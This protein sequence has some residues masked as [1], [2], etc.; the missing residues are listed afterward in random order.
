MAVRRDRNGRWRYR[1]VV[2]L[3]SGARTR[4]SGTPALNT[5][6]D[7]ER[8][9]RDHIARVLDPPPAQKEVLTLERFIED[10]WWPVYPSAAGNRRTTVREKER[11]IRLYIKPQLGRVKL[12]QVR[13]EALDRF[14]AFLKQRKLSEKSRKNVGA[15]LR[16][17]LASAVEWDYLDAIP[18]FPKLRVPEADSD[19]F[20]KEES[21]LLIDKATD[22]EERALLMF[23]I[24]TGARQGEQ[25]GLSWGDIDWQNN[26]VVFRRAL[27]EGEVGPTKSGKVRKVPLTASF[28]AALKAIRHLRSERVFVQSDGKSFSS[29]Q[30]HDRLKR[31][32]R[33]AGLRRI[34][35]HDLRHSFGSQLAIAGVPLRQVQAWMGHS[36]IQ[37]TMRYA[38]L[39]PNGGAELIAA[40][41]APAQPPRGNDVAKPA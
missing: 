33:R 12:D 38:H 2:Q 40:L 3:P 20:T 22:P 15:T 31:A 32:C 5:K 35:W 26:L 23:A 21:A 8:A 11:H 29:W 27:I 30:L 19:F 17:I 9:E 4:I 25:L 18:P 36:T 34:R 14:F 13:G 1:A 24:H 37:M 6:R 10:K 28:R 41:D 39:A 7:A 16:R